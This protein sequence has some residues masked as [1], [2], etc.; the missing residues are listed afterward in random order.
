[1]VKDMKKM[2]LQSAMEYLM[3][4]G[5]AILII[6]VVLAV[7]FALGIFGNPIT[8]CVASPGYLCQNWLM[9]STSVNGL[10]SFTA[11]Q[12]T[13]STEYNIGFACASTTT[14][15]GLPFANGA[16]PWRFPQEGGS[17]AG[18]NGIAVTISTTTPANP[19]TLVTG[20]S[21][22][23]GNVLCFQSSGTPTSNTLGTSFSGTLYI[24]YTTAA[25]AESNSNP[26]Q[27]AKFA[28]VSIKVT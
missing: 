18:T 16:N 21:V 13:G 22:Y 20:Q 3:T 23:V 19:L 5:W 1:M 28:T 7:L 26:W 4:Y 24:N 14:V 8:G 27:T 12:N 2:R 15:S 9:N 25:G 6:A 11:G 17:W 10:L